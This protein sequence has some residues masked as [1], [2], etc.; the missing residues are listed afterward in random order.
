MGGQTKFMSE[1]LRKQNWIPEFSIKNFGFVRMLFGW[2]R[3]ASTRRAATNFLEPQT[4]FF[5]EPLREII[6]ILKFRIKHIG[7]AHTLF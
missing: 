2:S 6:W 3:S 1:P 5:H 4:K 7:F